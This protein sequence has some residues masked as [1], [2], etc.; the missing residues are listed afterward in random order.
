M[1]EILRAMKALNERD[2]P[3]MFWDDTLPPDVNVV[4]FTRR[5]QEEAAILKPLMPGLHA[6]IAAMQPST[7]AEARDPESG[8]QNTVHPSNTPVPD[9]SKVVSTRERWSR[10]ESTTPLSELQYVVSEI[11]KAGLQQA[12]IIFHAILGAAQK[13]TTDAQTRELTM[14]VP[15]NSCKAAATF[16]GLFACPTEQLFEILKFQITSLGYTPD[17]GMIRKTPTTSF[18]KAFK[19]AKERARGQERVTTV[20]M[21]S[22]FDVHILELAA[23]GNSEG[24]TSFA[25]TFVV[26]VGPEGVVVWQ[27]LGYDWGELGYGLD[28]YVARDGAKVRSWQEAGDFADR[29]DKLTQH[30]VCLRRR[31]RCV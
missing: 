19:A 23:V 27:G 17:L 4:N 18:L 12:S 20:M 16:V 10:P 28:E 22:L 30:K 11:F 6:E 5:M 13:G 1:E 7:N 14:P 15:W 2:G 24:Y 21:V 29:F 3:G 9:E 25:H 31:C 26:G 8:I